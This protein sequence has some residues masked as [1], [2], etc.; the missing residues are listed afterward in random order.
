MPRRLPREALHTPFLNPAG[1]VH[2]TGLSIRRK[3]CFL[4]VLFVITNQANRDVPQAAGAGQVHPRAVYRPMQRILE[5]LW[6]K[7][8]SSTKIPRRTGAQTSSETIL[9]DA[10]AALLQ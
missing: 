7:I 3:Q 4:T 5:E 8:E 10:A 2:A 9:A 6:A 1:Y